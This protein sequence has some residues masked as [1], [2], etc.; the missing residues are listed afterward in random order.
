M[1]LQPPTMI[2]NF[3]SDLDQTLLLLSPHEH[4]VGPHER[5]FESLPSGLSPQHPILKPRQPRRTRPGLVALSNRQPKG[6]IYAQKICVV[7]VLIPGRYLINPLASNLKLRVFAVNPGPGILQF[8]S[9]WTQNAETLVYLPQ[10]QE[11]R[12][13][14][15]LSLLKIYY[16]SR[17]EVGSNCLSLLFT[18]PVHPITLDVTLFTPPYQMVAVK[19]IH[20]YVCRRNNP[21]SDLH[22]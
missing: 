2:R 3:R 10:Q 21:G 16:D 12:V 18:T 11:T 7:T 20:F 9:H 14:G 5:I 13:L 4:V 8:T 22:A 15:D 19:N 6:R 17:I 1:N